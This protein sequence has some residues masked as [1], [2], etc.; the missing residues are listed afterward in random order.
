M[1]L[2]NEQSKRII[3]LL[4]FSDSIKIEDGCCWTCKDWK[5]VV[6]F[7]IVDHN[8]VDELHICQDCDQEAFDG[9]VEILEDN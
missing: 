1:Y 2:N 9:F 7:E 3:K 4:D 5:E 8:G 6:K